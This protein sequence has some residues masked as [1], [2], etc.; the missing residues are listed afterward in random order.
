[1]VPQWPQWN[2]DANKLLICAFVTKT[3][4]FITILVLVQNDKFKLL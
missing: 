1:L 3:E 4:S 2:S